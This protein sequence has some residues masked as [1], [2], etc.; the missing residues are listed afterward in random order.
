MS[1]EKKEV[2]SG[3]ILKTLVK[4][5]A[6]AAAREYVDFLEAQKQPVQAPMMGPAPES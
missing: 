4:Q 6:F 5:G 2:D 3:E 1:E